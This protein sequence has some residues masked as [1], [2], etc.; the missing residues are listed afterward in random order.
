MFDIGMPEFMVIAVVALVVLGPER[1]P[2]VMGK[3]G[4]GYRQLRTMSNELLSE[5]R[6]QWEAGMQ[7]VEGVTNTISGTW[8]DA[9]AQDDTTPAA[10]PPRVYQVPSQMEQP[11]TAANAGPWVLH[12]MHRGSTPDVE[13]SDP[14]YPDSPT[15][16]PRRA[17]A[18]D[19]VLAEDVAGGPMLMGPA[20]TEDE[21]AAWSYDLPDEPLDEPISGTDDLLRE[22]QPVPVAGGLDEDGAAKPAEPVSTAMAAPVPTNGAYGTHANG[23]ATAV[24]AADLHAATTTTNGAAGGAFRAPAAG[25]VHDEESVEAIRER[26]IIELY[27]QG[28]LTADAAAAALDVETD[29][30]LGYVE[31]VQATEA[32]ARV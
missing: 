27:R 12:A 19:D 15:A 32:K 16:L 24:T 29:E 5:A 1:L 10:P 25:W 22:A 26:T 3:I 8:Q 7:E 20:V 17:P 31:L 21:L 11:T 14:S 28:S 2:E 13:V 9:T 18:S 6:S 30:F 4:R 23:A